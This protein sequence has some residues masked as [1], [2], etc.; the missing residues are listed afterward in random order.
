MLATNLPLA[1]VLALLVAVLAAVPARAFPP[2]PPHELYGRV[3]DAFGNPIADGAEVILESTSGVR[4]TGFVLE[5]TEPGINYRLLVPLDAGLTDE[6]YQPTALMP[7][8]PFRLRVVVGGASFLPLEMKASSSA[9][10]A[11]GGRTR[12][13]LTLAVD[14]DGNGLPDLWEKAAAAALGIRWEAGVI[15]PDDPYPGSGLTY[16]QAYLAGTYALD[17]KE[18]FALSIVPDSGGASRLAFT[19]VRGRTYVVQTGDQLGAWTS[20][21][22]RIPGLAPEP[23]SVYHATETRRIEVEAVVPAE[24]AGN[25]RFFRLGVD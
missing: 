21:P 3:R 18:G 5:Q 7:A 16:R 20:I 17:P 1:P 4:L 23:V 8:A 11:P 2:A 15:R 6:P 9:I 13:D 25:A 22:F 12:L 10:G 24:T 19:A 14:A